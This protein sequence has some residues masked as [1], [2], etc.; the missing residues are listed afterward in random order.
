MHLDH[1]KEFE[2][3]DYELSE[4]FVCVMI[5][6]LSKYLGKYDKK[7][8]P[9]V[10]TPKRTPEQREKAKKV[11][12]AYVAAYESRYGIIPTF[13]KKEHALVYT[14]IERAGFDEA[15][16]LAHVY[17]AYNDPWHLKIKHPFAQLVRDLDK[18]RV[19]LNDPRRMLDSRRA[20]KQ[21]AEADDN[22]E[23]QDKKQR[24]KQAIEEER[25]QIA[26]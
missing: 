23:L 13:S 6:N 15:I 3:I 1:I 8:E 25:R 18:V 5:P 22:I 26:Q 17:P 19:E 16:N 21:I 14:L 12:M 24:A 7:T 4:S 11:K 20:Q 9:V 10:L 2:F